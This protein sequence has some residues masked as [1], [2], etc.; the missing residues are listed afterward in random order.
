MENTL[1][2]PM[3]FAVMPFGKKSPAGK[4]VGWM[5]R[6]KNGSSL[7]WNPSLKNPM[8]QERLEQTCTD[9]LR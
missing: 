5:P 8:K 7:I 9:N 3:C 4:Q 2:Q 1:P 6:G